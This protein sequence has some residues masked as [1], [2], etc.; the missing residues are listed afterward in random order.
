MTSIAL[1]ILT[2]LL[3]KTGKSSLFYTVIIDVNQEMRV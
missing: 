2:F 3:H 1:P